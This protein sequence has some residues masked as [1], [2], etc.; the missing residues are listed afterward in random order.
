MTLTVRPCSLAVVDLELM[1]DDELLQGNRVTALGTCIKNSIPSC[2]LKSPATM[3]SFNKIPPQSAFSTCLVLRWRPVPWR[4]AL[5]TLIT[6]EHL[7]LP[8]A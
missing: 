8:P 1:G 3:Q 6:L 7:L 5:T 4:Y 2:A